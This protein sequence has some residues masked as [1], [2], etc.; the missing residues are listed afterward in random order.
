MSGDGGSGI[1]GMEYSFG[2]AYEYEVDFLCRLNSRGL[3]ARGG[4]PDCDEF[5]DTP[6]IFDSNWMSMV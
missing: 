1:V 6:L 4:D 2:K 5:G 3:N